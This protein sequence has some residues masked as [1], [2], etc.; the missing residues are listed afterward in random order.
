MGLETHTFW[1]S[2][3]FLQKPTT[4][5][6][7]GQL[8][9]NAAAKKAHTEAAQGLQ[10]DLSD[11]MGLLKLEW[12]GVFLVHQHGTRGNPNDVNAGRKMHD[13][14]VRVRDICFDL[15]S[16]ESG[17]LSRKWDKAAMAASDKDAKHRWNEAVEMGDMG[18]ECIYAETPDSTAKTNVK[19]MLTH[20]VSML[21][22]GAK[23]A[24]PRGEEAQRVLAAFMES[25]N[26]KTLVRVLKLF[27]LQMHW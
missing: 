18:L 23:G 3:A 27:T 13:A 25:L 4:R 10:G 16:P 19:R 26:N 15:T 14:A 21:E 24:Q 22:T 2:M 5:M 17:I 9:D 8:V 20:V 6:E 1:D 7:N 12:E 11:L